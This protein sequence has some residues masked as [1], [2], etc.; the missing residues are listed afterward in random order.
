MENYQLAINKSDKAVSIKNERKSIEK[1]VN[2]LR[3][4]WIDS[5]YGKKNL[6]I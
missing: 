4:K 2:Y 6:R 5:E 3:R 1:E